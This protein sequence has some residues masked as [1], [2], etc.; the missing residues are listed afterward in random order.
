MKS[1]ISIDLDFENKPIIKIEYRQSEDVRD[2]L[3]KRFLETFASQSSW[4]KI[5]FDGARD[6]AAPHNLD[7]GV[8]LIYPIA[9][10]DFE[11]ES[12]IM[13]DQHR[14]SKKHSV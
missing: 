3:V 1:R 11:K 6:Y 2:S 4:C 5:K 7:A 14:V 9:P 13:N 12:E 8:S 10:S